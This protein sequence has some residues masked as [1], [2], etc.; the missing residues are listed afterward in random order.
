MSTSCVINVVNI[1]LL[2]NLCAVN[3]NNN[4]KVLC[5]TAL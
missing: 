3:P 1:L 2:N 5:D 4:Q